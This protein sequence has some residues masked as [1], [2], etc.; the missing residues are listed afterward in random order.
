[1]RRILRASL[2]VALVVL[3]FFAWR[4]FFPNPERVIRSRMNEL[5]KA[6]SFPAKEGELAIPLNASKLAGF[7]TP[8]VQ[9]SINLRGQT[10]QTFSGR[11]QI[12][13]AAIRARAF[14]NGLTVEF[15]GVQVTLAPDKRSSVVDLTARAKT[16]GED[17]SVQ[18]LKLTLEKAGRDWLVNRVETV[19]V[20]E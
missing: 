19:K 17:F 4:F 9:V 15:S 7:F 6:A 1:M 5:A 12:F 13:Q 20:F 14:A 3:G 10:A 16:P 18:E 8:D 11:D 2:L